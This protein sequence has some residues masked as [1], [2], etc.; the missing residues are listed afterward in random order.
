M[1]VSAGGER[2]GVV[3]HHHLCGLARTGGGDATRPAGGSGS[4][5]GS[6]Q[7]WWAQ[8]TDGQRPDAVARPRCLGRTDDSRRSA[9]AVA[10]DLQEYPAAGQRVGGARPSGQSAQ[11]VRLVGAVGLQP[12]GDAQDPRRGQAG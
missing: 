10:L 8:E 7:G 9:I 4:A 2:R 11:R 5:P 1:A 3:A 6:R 12:A